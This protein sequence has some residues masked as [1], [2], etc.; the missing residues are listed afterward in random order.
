MTVKPLTPT[1]KTKVRTG[2]AAY[3]MAAEEARL[4]WNY[5]QIRPYSGIGVDPSQHH[6][7]DCS[8]YIAL[9]F[10]WVMHKTGIYLLDP[11]NENY[12][13][14]GNTGTSL[15]FLKVHPAPAD[16]YLIGDMAIFG[17]AWHTV[18]MSICRKAGT[19]KTAIFSSNGH[20]SWVFN[21]D[22]PEPITLASEK[23]RQNLVGVYRHPQLI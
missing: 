3:C 17:T 11:L 1:K 10:N 8:A 16:K 14:L 9:V 4:K 12:S 6:V 18:H 23:A 13:G 19:S 21:R 15:A 2:I 22:A 20:E 7:D 5:A